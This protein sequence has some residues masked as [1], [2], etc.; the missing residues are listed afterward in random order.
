MSDALGALR[1]GLVVSCQAPPGSP[2]AE[3]G[4]M[5]AFARAAAAGGACGI[6]AEGVDDIVAIKRAVELPLIGLRKRR[7]PD[8]EVYITPE[9]EDARAVAGAGADIV[10]VDATLRPRPGPLDSESLL[11]EL[12]RELGVPVLADI[13]CVDAAVAA[14]GAGAAAVATT[15]S[16]YTGGDVPEGPDLGLVAQLA[17][18]LDCPVLAE[19][20]YASADLVREAFEAGAWAVVV[21][22]AITDPVSLTRR[23]SAASPRSLYAGR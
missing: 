5:V 9:L 16:G 22:A 20:R 10:A 1:G 6:R 4:H 18:E 21:G 14:R 23:F 2:L 11:G 17:A 19:G 8:S 7:V 13:D 3:T 12:T 15:L